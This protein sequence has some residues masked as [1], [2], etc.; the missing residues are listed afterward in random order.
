MF[1]LPL[2]QRPLATQRQLLSLGH[3]L[4]DELHQHRQKYPT[5]QHQ[6][7]QQR[8]AVIRVRHADGEYLWFDCT[9]TDLSGDPD[10]GGIVIVARDVTGE[11]RAE[12]ALDEVE[13]RYRATFEHSPLAI[14]IIGLD[15]AASPSK[16]ATLKNTR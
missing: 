3:Q 15:G 5:R 8:F 14:A 10:V 13:A 9:A 6:H 2:L 12:A 4:L 7:G 16:G 1:Y 11:Q